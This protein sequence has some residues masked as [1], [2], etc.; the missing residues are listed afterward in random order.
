MTTPAN[1]NESYCTFTLALDVTAGGLPS[2]EEI[3]K[4]LENHDP[5][6]SIP[7]TVASIRDSTQSANND[8][9]VKTQENDSIR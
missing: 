9:C 5:N 7:C 1:S 3:A 6:V 8:C 2:E 4:D